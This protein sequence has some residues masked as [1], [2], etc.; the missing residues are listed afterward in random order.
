MDHIAIMKKEWGLTE[1]IL[2][3]RKKI[4]SRWL[5]KR[6]V[7]WQKVSK[8]DIVYFKNSGEPVKIRTR[9]DRV[10]NIENLSR[11]KVAKILA[12]YGKDGGIEK[13]DIPKFRSMFKNK[14]YCVLVFLKNARHIKPFGIDKAGF[15]AMAAWICTENIGNVRKRL[16]HSG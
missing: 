8:N 6:T 16:A 14:K 9:V 13:C 1:K 10:V 12:K 11:S 5:S 3:G 7:P 15:G 4:E 2:D